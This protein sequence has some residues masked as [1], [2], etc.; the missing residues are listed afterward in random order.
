MK[1]KVRSRTT[2]LR[3]RIDMT[4]FAG[5]VLVLL[6]IFMS[7]TGYPY[8]RPRG[9]YVELAKASHAIP[10]P[11]AAREDALIVAIQ[12]DGKIFFDTTQVGPEDLAAKVKDRLRQGAP[13]TIYIKADA[14]ARYHHVAEAMDGVRLAGM[15][16]IVLLTEQR[17]GAPS[18]LERWHATPLRRHYGR[19]SHVLARQHDDVPFQGTSSVF[20]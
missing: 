12:R 9:R 11:G 13:G 5:V 4:V 3:C 20:A 6:F 10:M 16:S 15:V 8:D 14:R 7:I 1:Q 18:R 17:R 19:P 2:R